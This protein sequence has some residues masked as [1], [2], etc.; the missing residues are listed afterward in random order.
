M[1]R[2]Q[3]ADAKASTAP[4]LYG[5]ASRAWLA[6]FLNPKH[7][8]GPE[9]FGNTSHR[10]GTMVGFANDTLAG[11]PPEET[12]NVLLALS[13]EAGLKSQTDADRK[14]AERIEAG[15]KLI[16]DGERCASCH[17]FREA[18]HARL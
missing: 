8:A 18:L 9:Y 10:E 3:P 11:W 14:D 16:A 17:K 7:I 12:K 13:A 2:L 6:G 5:F 4:N 1:I 15:R